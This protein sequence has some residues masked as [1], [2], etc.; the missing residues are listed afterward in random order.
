ML[1][2]GR[3]LTRHI[4]HAIGSTEKPMTDQALPGKQINA[5]WSSG[6]AAAMIAGENASGEMVGDSMPGVSA[7]AWC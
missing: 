5:A 2:D 3:K 6:D 4:E 1:K 7:V